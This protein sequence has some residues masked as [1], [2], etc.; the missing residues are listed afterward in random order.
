MKIKNVRSA[1]I[2]LI[3]LALCG[4]LIFFFWDFFKAQVVLPLYGFVILIS[5]GIKSVPQGIFLFLLSAF[6]LVF[7]LHSLNQVFG[8]DVV[9]EY[10]PIVAYGIE[11][12]SRYEFWRNQCS[13]LNKNSFTHQEFM[14]STRRLILNILANQEHKEIFEIEQQIKNRDM[15]VPESVCEFL[16]ERRL[17][18]VPPKRNWTG[19]MIYRIQRLVGYSPETKMP[20]ALELQVAEIIEF[21]EYRLEIIYDD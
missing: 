11:V 1:V 16:C 9:E 5:F 13:H 21:I 17:R 14:L 20:A 3:T 10:T 18:V 12:V 8:K 7:I 4:I 2:I 15:A 6:C 19:R